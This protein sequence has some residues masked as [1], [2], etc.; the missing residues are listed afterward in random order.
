MTEEIA[1][2]EQAPTGFWSLTG[3]VSPFARWSTAGGSAPVSARGTYATAFVAVRSAEQSM[4]RVSS[5]GKPGNG[6]GSAFCAAASTSMSP[7]PNAG[8]A[9][10]GAAGAAPGEAPTGQGHTAR[11]EEP[12][13]ACWTRS[14][15]SRRGARRARA[16]RTGVCGEG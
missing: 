6:H 12:A 13:A 11:E 9:G 15:R 16:A 2:P 4:R 5:G 7:E 1:N 3:P 14:P 10:G 8:A